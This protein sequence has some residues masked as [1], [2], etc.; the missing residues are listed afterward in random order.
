ME[1]ISAKICGEDGEVDPA[2]FADCQEF[3][4]NVMQVE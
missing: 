4:L 2:C 1:L 3:V